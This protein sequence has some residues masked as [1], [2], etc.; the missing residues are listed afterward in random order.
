MTSTARRSILPSHGIIS[1]FRPLSLAASAT[2]V[3]GQCE[4]RNTPITLSCP[5]RASDFTRHSSMVSAP[6][7]PSLLI[8]CRIFTRNSNK[9]GRSGIVDGQSIHGL[10]RTLPSRKPAPEP[11]I[12]TIT[13]K[14]SE[15]FLRA[16]L[17]PRE[18]ENSA[19]LVQ[20]LPEACD[21]EIVL[22]RQSPAK[23]N[24]LAF[25]RS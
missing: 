13:H 25:R 24:S 19:L 17:S 8:S 22:Y 14:L 1:T 11:V 23:L 6:Y 2:S 15:Q 16:I 21:A 4:L 10:L 12:E 18:T 20:P 5:S 7:F 3:W 9:D